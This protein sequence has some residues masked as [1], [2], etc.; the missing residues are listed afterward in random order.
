[1][2]ALAQREVAQVTPAATP[3]PGLS[4]ENQGSAGLWLVFGRCGY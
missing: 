4:L 2:I 1:M 3:K